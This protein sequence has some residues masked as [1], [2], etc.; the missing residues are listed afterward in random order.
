MEFLESKHE[1]KIERLSQL[2]HT[3]QKLVA[4]LIAEGHT[5]EEAIEI[6]TSIRKLQ[7]E[8]RSKKGVQHVL[9]GA[10][11]LVS[12]FMFT[13]FCYHAGYSLEIP[14]YGITLVGLGI[15]LYGTY[16]ILD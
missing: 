6:A 9:V 10:G 13:V 5:Q 11:V 16:E 14:L 15:A 2:G 8:R 3:K 1:Q 7:N 4:L 12:G